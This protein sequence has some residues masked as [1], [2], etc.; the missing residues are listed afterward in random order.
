MAAELAALRFANH[1]NPWM[2]LALMV[3]AVSLFGGGLVAGARWERGR[4]ALEAQENEKAAEAAG[5]AAAEQI[6]RLRANAQSIKQG[7]EHEVRANPGYS[8]CHNTPAG[9]RALD[10]ALAGGRATGHL[11]LPDADA[12]QRR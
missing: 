9:L 6:A 4:A 3:L 5:R 11:E 7:I 8:D 10:A 1:V 2:V 12:A